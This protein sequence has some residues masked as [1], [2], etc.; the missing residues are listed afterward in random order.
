[1]KYAIVNGKVL[2]SRN[3]FVDKSLLIEEGMISDIGTCPDCQVMDADGCLVMPGIIDMHGDAFEKLISPRSGCFLPL[4]IA[5]YEADRQMMAS[6][7][8]TGYLSFTLTWETHNRLRSSEGAQKFIEAYTACR[9]SLQV[10]NKTHLRFEI[11]HLE[12]IPLVQSWLE[13][14]QVDMISFNDHLPYFQTLTADKQKLQELAV[15]NGCSPDEILSMH[16]EI[17]TLKPEALEGVKQLAGTCRNDDIV[18]ASHDEEDIPTRQWYQAVGCRICEFPC[19][20][21]VAG[22]AIDQQDAV[23][24]GAPNALNGGSLYSRLSVRECVDQGICSILASDYY[25]PAQLQAVFLMAH[26]GICDLAHGWDLVSKNAARALGLADRG[27]LEPGKRADVVIVDT[28]SAKRPS[29]RATLV[30]G[31]VAYSSR[32]ILFDAP[33]K[34]C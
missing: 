18:M 31:E 23:V 5:L 8:T 19:N 7:I 4:D 34:H 15:R 26:L 2:T 3:T 1:M 30:N 22:Y 29:V 28:T 10:A 9:K 6:G 21:T 32:P 12:A 33:G 16:Q 11:Y 27:T 14:R 25:Y 17:A 20:A 24:M 13:N